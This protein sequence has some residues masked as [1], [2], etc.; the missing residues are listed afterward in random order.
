MRYDR[1]K[2][3]ASLSVLRPFRLGLDDGRIKDPAIPGLASSRPDA[4]RAGTVGPQAAILIDSRLPAPR[5]WRIGASA[6]HPSD[7][8]PA[9]SSSERFCLAP[10]N[11]PT[12]RRRPLILRLL[13]CLAPPQRS[14]NLQSQEYSSGAAKT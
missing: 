5:T 3:P 6:L 7:A 4:Q 10:Q 8:A 13:R 14:S 12:P 9:R 2:A 11:R 1:V